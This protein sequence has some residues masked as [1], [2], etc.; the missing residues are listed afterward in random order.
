MTNQ[1]L[2][3][4][5][6]LLAQKIDHVIEGQSSI[7]DCQKEIKRDVKSIDDRLDNA[8]KTQAVLSV[9]IANNSQAAK[10]NSDKINSIIKEN[11]D[12][13]KGVFG[14]LVTAVASIV[15]AGFTL[16]QTVFSK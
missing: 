9:T 7:I 12:W 4:Q 15:V 5:I 6:A 13:R 16:L 10:D 11:S 3:S 1:P 2:E 8:E 14:S